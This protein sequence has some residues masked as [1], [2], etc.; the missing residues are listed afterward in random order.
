MREGNNMLGV[1][2][3]DTPPYAIRYLVD[4]L[5][6]GDVTVSSDGK[7]YTVRSC[8]PLHVRSFYCHSRN[9]FTHYMVNQKKLRCRGGTAR[10]A[11]S[12][13]I[14]RNVANMFLEL[15]WMCVFLILPD[16]NAVGSL[17]YRQVRLFPSRRL[18]PQHQRVPAGWGLWQLRG[19][20]WQL[21][22]YRRRRPN[23]T[24][25]H[26]GGQH[27]WTC[28]LCKKL[29][30]SC[31]VFTT[32]VNKK[33]S[34]RRV[35]ARCVVSVEILPITTQQCRNYLYDKYWPNRWYEVGGLVGGSV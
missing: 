20:L 7:K 5:S 8:K 3:C 15:Q 16:H 33:L 29:H 19:T 10:C 24:G 35:T 30:V 4:P 18:L 2:A 22:R 1:Y 27:L 34:Y 11:M 9:I 26:H 32:L 6:P 28:R 25:H 14:M 17:H 12:V 23:N 21:Q 13:E 31:F